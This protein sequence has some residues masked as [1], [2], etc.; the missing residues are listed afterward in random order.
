MK[1]ATVRELHLE[2]SA[3]VRKVAGGETFVI[4]KAGTPVAELRPLQGP[5][6]TRR[7]PNR[8]AALKRLPRAMDS[9]RILEEDRS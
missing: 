2:T 8:E 1:R 6:P 9:G 4:E 3:I 5:P 7:L